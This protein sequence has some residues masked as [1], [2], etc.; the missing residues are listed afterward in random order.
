MAAGIGV[1]GTV[2]LEDEAAGVAGAVAGWLENGVG[3]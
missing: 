1:T 3:A 2:G